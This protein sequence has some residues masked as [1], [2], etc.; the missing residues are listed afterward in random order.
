MK[1][2]LMEFYDKDYLEN[3]ISLFHRDYDGV[4]FFHFEDPHPRKRQHLIEF[5]K[6]HYQLEAQFVKIDDN[7][8]ALIASQIIEIM[9]KEDLYDFDITGGSELFSV[10]TGYII[11]KY[12]SYKTMVH[13]YDV[14]T[15][16]LIYN[17]NEDVYLR[18]E[19]STAT[20]EEII[21]MNG[22]KVISISNGIIYNYLNNELRNE[23]LRVWNAIKVI[24]YEWNKFCS[25]PFVSYEDNGKTIYQRK[26]SKQGDEKIVGRVMDRLTRLKIIV[27]W[28]YKMIGVNRYCVYEMNSI[29]RTRDLYEKSGSALE[30]YTCL[31]AF[32]SCNFKDCQTG[33][34]IDLNGIITNI[35]ADPRNEIDVVL[36]YNHTP[37]F[38]SCK[39]TQ[40]TKE[41]LYEIKVM[42]QQY[43]GKYAKAVLVTIAKAIEPVRQRALEMD[44][45]LL[46]GVYQHTLT[47]FKEELI[48]YF[49]YL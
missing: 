19:D 27:D 22:G 16:T 4:Y 7:S 15:D 31:A 17:N 8:V 14:E 37:I 35:P 28:Q 18:K 5:I 25:L 32:D 40:P 6:E 23:I 30:M 47:Q 43:G 49:P 2:Y 24:P 10:A 33:V 46:D 42:A 36:I 13:Q 45:I 1:T 44:V 9:N 21:A 38:I 11:G 34:L 20:I 39:N 41:F 3:L 48:K 26:C 12:R 29:S